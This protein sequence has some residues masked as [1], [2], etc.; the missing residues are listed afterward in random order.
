MK[1]FLA[2]LD[3]SRGY[4]TITFIQPYKPRLGIP[5]LKRRVTRTMRRLTAVSARRAVKPATDENSGRTQ[6]AVAAVRSGLG[7]ASRRHDIL[8]A[9][10]SPDAAVHIRVAHPGQS[11]SPLSSSYSNVARV[12]E[13]RKECL[14]NR[15][16]LVLLKGRRGSQRGS[17]GGQEK[18]HSGP[19]QTCCSANT[20]DPY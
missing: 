5:I 14:Q 15:S 9:H 20:A 8:G 6:A 17:D 7:H 16:I 19:V 13:D 12:F 4:N 10:R 1:E 18:G 2:E 3:Q 11:Y